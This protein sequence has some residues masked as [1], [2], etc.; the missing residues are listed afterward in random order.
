[1][2]LFK[3]P[4]RYAAWLLF[5]WLAI[6]AIWRYGVRTVLRSK[7]MLM[8]RPPM[9]SEHRSR[10][11]KPGLLRWMPAFVL[12]ARLEPLALSKCAAATDDFA[13]WHHGPSR[14]R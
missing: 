12:Y 7:P 11:D 5:T 6:L 4:L 13:Q 2:A 3:R 1:M 9:L 10:T 14:N 8:S